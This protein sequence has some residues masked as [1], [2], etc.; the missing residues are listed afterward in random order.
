MWERK[1]C[2]T[3]RIM[4]YILYGIC[5]LFLKFS[6]TRAVSLKFESFNIKGSQLHKVCLLYPRKIVNLRKFK[7]KIFIH[8]TWKFVEIM[9]PK[10]IQWQKK[11]IE[12]I[13]IGYNNYFGNWEHT[14]VWAIWPIGLFIKGSELFYKSVR[15]VRI[16]LCQLIRI[17]EFRL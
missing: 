13:R 1:K 2:I 12:K 17:T 16:I 10:F 14:P 11:C 4:F 5:W 8:I 7:F 9:T 3:L 6:F 15:N